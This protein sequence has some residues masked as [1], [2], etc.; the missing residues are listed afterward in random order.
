MPPETFSHPA[1]VLLTSNR[2]LADAVLLPFSLIAAILLRRYPIPLACCIFLL[3]D[4]LV[5]FI[6][7]LP[8]K[9]VGLI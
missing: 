7:A 9:L 8:E 2:L 3:H 5:S 6:S 1:A 4:F